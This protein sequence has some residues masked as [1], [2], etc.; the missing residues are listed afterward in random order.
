M[1]KNVD[2]VA[3]TQISRRQRG[4]VH[5]LVQPFLAFAWSNF[6]PGH[7]GQFASLASEY[8]ASA[9]VLYRL[10]EGRFG[11]LHCHLSIR[12]LSR[13]LFRKFLLNVVKAAKDPAKE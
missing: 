11:R 9:Q 5:L 13:V 6:P 1:V 12:V 7:T 10:G 2:Q 8:L 4:N 3:S